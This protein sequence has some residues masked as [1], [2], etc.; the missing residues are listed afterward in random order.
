MRVEMLMGGVGNVGVLG[1]RVGDVG[2][3]VVRCVGGDVYGWCWGG[4][5]FV[6]V[7]VRVRGCGGCVV[8]CVGGDVDGWCL[9][10]GFCGCASWGC[11][12]MGE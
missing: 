10:V 7:F 3:W 2:G 11:G 9:G 4:L 1:V 5:G 12:E 6:V 8:R